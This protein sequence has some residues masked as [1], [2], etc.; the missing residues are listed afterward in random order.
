MQ[1][2]ALARMAANPRSQAVPESLA[3]VRNKH[4]DFLFHGS[5]GLSAGTQKE[6]SQAVY[7]VYNGMIGG[8][9]PR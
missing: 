3:R 5:A 8:A 1:P 2:K 4:A 9:F 6:A 7:P